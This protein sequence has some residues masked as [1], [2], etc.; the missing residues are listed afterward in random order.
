MGVKVVEVDAD[1]DLNSFSRLG[2]GFGVASKFVEETAEM[3]KSEIN[4]FK[5]SN[6]NVADAKQNISNTLSSWTCWAT[7]SIGKLTD[8]LHQELAKDENEQKN[9][10]NNPNADDD[11][12][13]SFW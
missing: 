8:N 6:K 4:E 10:E 2:L 11:L 1:E 5:E 3:A 9:S 12:G 13:G 7:N